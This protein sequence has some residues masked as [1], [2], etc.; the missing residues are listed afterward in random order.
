MIIPSEIFPTSQNLREF[1]LNKRIFSDYSII[2]FDEFNE[3]QKSFC[4]NFKHLYFINENYLNPIDISFVDPENSCCIFIS[5]SVKTIPSDYFSRF[6]KLTTFY[7]FAEIQELP[8]HC[9]SYSQS[10]T[11]IH[12]PQIIRTIGKSCFF[13]CSNLSAINI[14]HSL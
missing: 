8:D 4:Q 12:L 11:K 3:D 6:Q 14:P 9:F 2:E 7:L 13:G 5:P 1:I 10:L